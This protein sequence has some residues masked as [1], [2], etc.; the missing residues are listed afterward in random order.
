[1]TSPPMRVQALRLLLLAQTAIV[2]WLWTWAWRAVQAHAWVGGGVETDLLERGL[3]YLMVLAPAV[4]V[5]LL[6]AWWLGAGGRRARLYL[7]AAGALTAVQQILLLIP[8]DPGRSMAAGA[9]FALT[10]GPVAFAGLAIAVTGEAKAWL[11]GEREPRRGRVIGLETAV[12]T[13]AAIL[14]VGVAA[15]VHRWVGAASQ[16]GPPVGEFDES[17]LWPRMEEA[18]TN[19]AVSQAE[20]PGFESRLVEVT[21]CGYRTESGL[22]TYRYR[23]TYEM[24]PFPTGASEQAYTTAV[25]DRWSSDD[26]EILYEGVTYEGDPT[27]TAHRQDDLTLLL[28]LRERPILEIQSGCLERVAE[29]VPCIDPQGDVPASRD[30]IEGLP[31]DAER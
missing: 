13:M 30:R 7:A 19:A 12:W 24:A 20:F 27:I 18:V 14:A 15:D 25:R 9:V 8:V 16:T 26:Y 28:A 29:A 6:A 11:G 2:V 10:V 23:I 22:R 5:N 4:P 3:S 21:A 17:D 1:M 31:C